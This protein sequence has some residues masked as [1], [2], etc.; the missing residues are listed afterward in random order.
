MVFQIYLLSCFLL[1]RLD[2]IPICVLH[3]VPTLLPCSFSNGKPSVVDLY[4]QPFYGFRRL[5]VREFLLISPVS[6]RDQAFRA[7]SLI[8]YFLYKLCEFLG[9]SIVEFTTWFL[10]PFMQGNCT[11]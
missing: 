8:V 10:S 5:L 2:P 6:V 11:W 4:F 3:P 9:S 1:A 7:S